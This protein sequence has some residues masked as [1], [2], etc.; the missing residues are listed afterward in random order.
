MKSLRKTIDILD[1]LSDV[2]RDVG[3]TELS[4]KLNLP[5]STVHRILK[6]L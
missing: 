2:K 5:K 1:Y 3:I 6:D 4:L